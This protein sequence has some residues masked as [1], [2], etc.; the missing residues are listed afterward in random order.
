MEE[1][2]D[3]AAVVA[4][5]SDNGCD[6]P[7]CPTV[8]ILAHRP[9][10]IKSANKEDRKKAEARFKDIID[11]VEA[12]DPEIK[13][14]LATPGYF[15]D[16]VFRLT[17]LNKKTILHQIVDNQDDNEDDDDDNSESSDNENNADDADAAHNADGA[18]STVKE[19][20]SGN[21]HE[22]DGENNE[23]LEILVKGIVQNHPDMLLSQDKNQ[24]TPLQ[25]AIDCNCIHLVEWMCSTEHKE[26]SSA[27]STEHP[28]KKT[29]CL[30][31]AMTSPK[32]PINIILKMI[33]ISDK[34]AIE[35]QNL[36]GLTPLHLA[37]QYENCQREK[38]DEVVK[39]L[40]TKNEG[41]LDI[42][43]TG[44]EA[45][46]VIRYHDDDRY[47][48]KKMEKY[49]KRKAKK[50]AD[51]QPTSNVDMQPSA[52]KRR[53]TNLGNAEPAVESHVN[54]PAQPPK[55][56]DWKNFEKRKERQSVKKDRD[57]PK[58]RHEPNKE[59][60][61][62][63]QEGI[64][65]QQKAERLESKADDIRDFIKLH[66]FRT[67]PVEKITDWLFADN[68]AGK[69]SFRLLLRYYNNV[70]WIIPIGTQ[71]DFDLFEAGADDNVVKQFRVKEFCDVYEHFEFD[72]VLKSVHFRSLHLTGT[73]KYTFRDNHKFVALKE[74][75]GCTD[76]TFLF[77]WLWHSKG[78]RRIMNVTMEDRQQPHSDEAIERCL[79]RFR[80]ESLDWQKI[81][82]C[83]GV[84]A[85]VGSHLRNISLHWSGHNAVLRG[86]GEPEGLSKCPQLQSITLHFDS[87]SYG[88]PDLTTMD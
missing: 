44:P 60:S 65:P 56:D 54:E 79:E 38:W 77:D 12:K 61:V 88:M 48:P 82:L 49:R 78:V 83:P 31:K 86:W 23:L 11:K 14:A 66:Y 43:G 4:S 76:I 25:A 75:N 26:L 53:G 27:I 68:I 84:I 64:T 70:M 80:V 20:E 17:A 73:E 69:F 33:E 2:K 8:T 50:I 37:M 21:Y 85:T 59:I 28:S 55:L 72:S 32:L 35:G 46:S 39:A 10:A 71:I 74:D 22:I 3:G 62:K 24:T 81:D 47:K 9:K 18:N 30:H 16:R 52:P 63:L 42:R 15:Q 1:S 40:I 13:N 6:R 34:K 19:D 29:N 45:Y 67:Y 36:M 51:S 58:S 57:E 5:P 7:E 41:A 87:V